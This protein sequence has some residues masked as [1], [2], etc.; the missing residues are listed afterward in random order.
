VAAE[1]SARALAILT[2]SDHIRTGETAS[3]EDR[4]RTFDDMVSVALQMLR[5]DAA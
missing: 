1:R 5:L 3:S 4:E 2:V